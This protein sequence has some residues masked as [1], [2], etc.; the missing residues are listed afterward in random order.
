MHFSEQLKKKKK[1]KRHGW[2]DG[3]MV[4]R[5][6]IGLLFARA[7]RTLPAGQ[8]HVIAARQSSNGAGINGGVQWEITEKA[9]KICIARHAHCWELIF[10]TS[11]LGGHVIM[12]V[13]ARTKIVHLLITWFQN[14][15]LT[16]G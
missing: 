3:W 8:Q 15:R 11:V 12:H 10:W 7:N 13:I 14:L 6:R 16:Y 1:E 9:R 2:M 5:D 4:D